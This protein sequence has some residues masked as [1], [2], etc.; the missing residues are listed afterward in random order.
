MHI[1][2]RILRAE[3]EDR[4]GIRLDLTGRE[5]EQRDTILAAATN[6]M[7][8]HGRHA[9]TLAAFALA[10]RMPAG[11]IRRIFPDLDNLLGEILRRHL[12]EIA[13][14]IGRVAHDAPNRAAAR[15]AAYLEYTRGPFGG[16]TPAHTL[17]VRDRHLLPPDE[18]E[19]VEAT[20][21]SIGLALAGDN[22]ATA[23]ALL[24]APE[25]E[26]PQIEAALAVPPA[27]IW[28]R[29]AAAAPQTAATPTETSPLPEPGNPAEHAAQDHPRCAAIPVTWTPSPPAFT[30][31]PARAGPA[32]PAKTGAAGSP[33]SAAPP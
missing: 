5:I 3:E 29:P 26:L 16:L 9:I 17:L 30:F 22:G 8:R 19:S 21:A 6:H 24:D 2:A 27:G 4:S 15:R 32:R 7:A 25:V 1:P 31:E 11:A 10:L 20:R 33:L 18:S 13:R 23:L 28:R 14:A 12:H